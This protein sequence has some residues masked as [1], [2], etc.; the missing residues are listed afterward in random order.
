[1][2][3]SS[4]AAFAMVVI[5]LTLLGNRPAS[6]HSEL[7]RSDPPAGGVIEVGRSTLTLWFSEAI[8][9]EASIFECHAADGIPVAVSAST[10]DAN[11]QSVVTIGVEPLAKGAYELDW[12]VLSAGDGHPSRGSIAFGAGTG[13]AGT[14]VGEGD[15]PQGQGL[16]IRWLDLSVLMLT[17]GALAVSGRV[18]G[19]IGPTRKDPLRRARVIGATAA[20]A[21]VIFG[22]IT[23]FLRTPHGGNSLGVWFDGTWAALA[24][25]S[26]G[27]LWLARELALVIAA[28]ALWSWASRSDGSRTSART[29]AVAMVAVVWFEALTGHA[30]D[31]SRQSGLAA[32]ASATH[33]VA[34][35]VWA[36]GLAVLALCLIPMMRRDPDARGPMVA[37][38]WRAFSPMAAIA[39]VV[40]L[41]TG[42]YESGRHVP[43]LHSVTSTVYGG[44]V[45]G[46][47]L[48]VCVA[49]FL[50]GFNTLLVNPG[51]SEPIA[52]ILGRPVGWAPVSLRRFTSVVMAEVA[53]LIVAV[54]AGALLT[55]VPTSREVTSARQESAPHSANVDGLF[56]TFES[57][58]AGGEHDRL[59]VRTHSTIKPEPG[60]ITGV[61]VLLA[62]PTEAEGVTLEL[63][64]PGRYEA[65]AQ[66]SDAGTWRASVAV[67][68]DGLPDAVTQ[69]EWTVADASSEPVAPLELV[70]TGL[71]VLLLVLLA[72]AIGLVG[73]ASRHPSRWETI[74]EEHPVRQR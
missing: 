61:D 66:A 34:A 68:R 74:D 20:A 57:V 26:W 69:A 36:G 45:A 46:K 63:V 47:I 51:L 48:L 41:A 17:I 11:G 18:L 60:P 10:T 22:A 27:Q 32:I 50:A 73:R 23:P 31:L 25:T 19:S 37:S 7:E 21:A 44:A 72:G 70:T 8:I 40:L 67:H 16:L 12:T 42:L 35:G 29:A 28:I 14:S 65:E 58:P 71:A 30:S 55:S 53:V 2:R 39:T 1:M 33:L 64:E 13:A 43:D 6:A 3:A 24:R 62:G 52:R 56:V 54:V 9:A 4:R 38:A 15:F 59:I 49:L 5:G